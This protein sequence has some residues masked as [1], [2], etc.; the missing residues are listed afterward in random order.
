MQQ[1]ATED[2]RAASVTIIDAMKLRRAAISSFVHEWAAS[3]LLNVLALDLDCVNSDAQ[4]TSFKI[5]I[6]SIGSS[7]VDSPATRQMIDYVLAFSPRIPLVILADNDDPE[8]VISAFRAGVCGFIPTK[9]EPSL[10][11]KALSFI[12]SGGTFFPPSALACSVQL[13]SREHERAPHVTLAEDLN[14]CIAPVALTQRQ[15]EVLQLLRLGKSNKAIAQ[16]LGMHEPT[17]K[18]HVRQIMRKFD[19]VNRTEVAIRVS[20]QVKPASAPVRDVA[21]PLHVRPSLIGSISSEPN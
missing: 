17:V 2:H 13:S 12:L 6:L 14:E 9:M 11:L 18:V 8:Q 10:A 4:R 3:N 15:Q 20:Q 7:S 1:D 5:V 16:E 21:T 19:A